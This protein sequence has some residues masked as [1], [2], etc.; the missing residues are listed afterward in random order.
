MNQRPTQP[1][2]FEIRR[3]GPMD[4]AIYRDL[5]LEGLRQHP[6]AFSASWADEASKPDPWFAERLTSSFV[7]G[8]RI[9]GAALS[10]VAG[11]RVP[12]SPKLRHKAALWGMFVRADARG[13]GLAAALLDAT[14]EQASGM[15]EEIC[16]TVVT[17]NR[18]AM[19]PYAAA[20]FQDYGMERRALK[21]GDTYHDEMFMA[22]RL[23]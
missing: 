14:I 11:L 20:G 19:R 1:P 21:I 6:E 10:G 4:A 8:G 13:T 18:A 22:L 3:L 16:L 17:T 7:F 23:D 12:T 15:V 5:R 9:G 2:Q